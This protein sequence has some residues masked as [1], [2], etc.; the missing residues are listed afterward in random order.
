MEVTIRNHPKDKTC[1]YHCHIIKIKFHANS[2]ILKIYSKIEVCISKG[3]VC[4]YWKV[5]V[6]GNLKLVDPKGHVDR[7][8]RIRQRN[9]DWVWNWRC[10]GIDECWARIGNNLTF[11]FIVIPAIMSGYEL[12]ETAVL[13][14]S[15]SIRLRRTILRVKLYFFVC[16]WICKAIE[17]DIYI[18]LFFEWKFK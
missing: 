12:Q 5:L 10:V 7:S 1:C 13:W 8:C 17:S 6:V 14:I 4:D 16:W 2:I 11:I 18:L 9:C 15:S 3:F